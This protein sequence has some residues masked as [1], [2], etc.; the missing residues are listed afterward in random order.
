LRSFYADVIDSL[1]RWNAFWY[2]DETSRKNL[3]I[4]SDHL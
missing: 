3:F 1:P 2:I 4:I